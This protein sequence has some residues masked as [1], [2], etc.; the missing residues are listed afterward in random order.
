[1]KCDIGELLN[2]DTGDKGFIRNVVT[3][4]LE[5]LITFIVYLLFFAWIGWRR[6]RLREGVVFVVGVGAWLV[7]QEYGSIFARIVN[8]FSKFWTFI[9][10]GGLGENQDDAFAALK[11]APQ[12]VTADNRSVFLFLLWVLLLVMLYVVTG[13]V[14]G[15]KSNKSDLLAAFLGMMN[16]LF[17]AVIFV[18]R[19]TEMMTMVTTTAAGE[20]KRPSLF[21]LI[22]ILGNGGTLLLTSLTTLW[23]GVGSS[24]RSLIL[25]ILLTL[26]L[27][28]VASTLVGA[29]KDKNKDRVKIK[30]TSKPATE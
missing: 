5:V 16:G 10:S 8:L 7:L 2:T 12:I 24:Q 25:L 20:L 18:P 3:D 27:V 29:K 26:F 6:G 1:M 14:L 21:D 11:T 30:R 23:D 15:G 9:Q 13:K 19:L 17:Y 22:G 28:F 4:Q